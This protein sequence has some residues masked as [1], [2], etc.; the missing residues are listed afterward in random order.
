MSHYD[1]ELTLAETYCQTW[2]A[3]AA[4]RELFQNGMD[5]SDQGYPFII[6][7]KK[8]LDNTWNLELKNVGTTI[9]K[10]SLLLGFTTKEDG[11]QRGQYGEG[12]KIAWLVLQRQGIRVE[13]YNG[14]ELWTVYLSHSS[15]FDTNTLHVRIESLL[16]NTPDFIVRLFNIPDSDYSQIKKRIIS[17]SF[18]IMSP[19]I[20]Q[21]TEYYGDILLDTCLAGKIF[22][23]GL[24]V[25]TIPDLYFGYNIPVTLDR[26]R[27]HV[28]REDYRYAI[29]NL[30]SN[31]ISTN[32]LPDDYLY[33]LLA[34]GQ[35]EAKAFCSYGRWN[36]YFKE[37]IHKEWLA[38]YPNQNCYPS[39]NS[40][41]AQLIRS[42]GLTSVAVSEELYAF[43]EAAGLTL[44]KTK[45]DTILAADYI[46]NSDELSLQER[47]NLSC[48]YHI[49]KR[50][51]SIPPI[52]I[53][54]FRNC[55][56]GL[57]FY[58]SNAMTEKIYLSKHVLSSLKMT[59]LALIHEICH[60]YGA[61]YTSEHINAM[62]L[63]WDNIYMEQ[64]NDH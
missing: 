6:S 53:V 35:E 57:H 2:D 28:S 22:S 21:G 15:C 59:L 32:K 23:R 8:N 26:D 20:I 42:Y 24:Y 9:P 43:L 5:A 51:M 47:A 30:Y 7:E 27:N 18:G 39:K 46:Y 44:D 38:K 17:P 16:E 31:L 52:Y 41:E 40:N 60:I 45:M 19:A 55:F 50:H 36:H 48:A 58:G 3:W 14:Q 34:L 37:R 4:V 1:I 63:L 11:S 10:H 49:V 54:K 61:D 62:C 25:E 64:I 13:C 12:Y 56:L 29:T 33:N